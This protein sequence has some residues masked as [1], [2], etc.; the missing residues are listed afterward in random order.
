MFLTFVFVWF[1][2]LVLLLNFA[3]LCVWGGRGK[4]SGSGW[5]LEDEWDRDARREIHKGAINKTAFKTKEGKEV[6]RSE[7]LEAVSA[8]D[9]EIEHHKHLTL[10][11]T[12][13]YFEHINNKNCNCVQS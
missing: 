3:L 1:C 12:A 11:V 8:Q 6:K 7:D 10:S 2:I 9:E 4:E 5:G 13:L